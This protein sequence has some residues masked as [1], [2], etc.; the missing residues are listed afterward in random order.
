[1]YGVQH[2]VFLDPDQLAEI[3]RTEPSAIEGPDGATVVATGTLLAA[4]PDSRGSGLDAFDRL[5]AEWR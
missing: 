1:M 3:L 5:D 2:P 4:D